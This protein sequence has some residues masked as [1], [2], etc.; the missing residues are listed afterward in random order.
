MWKISSQTQVETGDLG[1]ATTEMLLVPDDCT[2]GFF[3][4]YWKRPHAY[5]D[6]TV[7]EQFWLALLYRGVVS[8]HWSG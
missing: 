8:P 5:L 2:D 4:A 7:R 1:P 3:G 6:A